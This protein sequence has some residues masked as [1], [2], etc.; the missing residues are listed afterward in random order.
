MT[1]LTL[2][3]GLAFGGFLSSTLSDTVDVDIEWYWL[4]IA[5]WIVAF[6]IQYVGVRSRPAPS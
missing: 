5:F 2:A 1:A 4:A 3:I 6:A